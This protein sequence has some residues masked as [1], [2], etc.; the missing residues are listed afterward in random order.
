[1]TYFMG[2]W[3]CDHR[4]KSRTGVEWKQW[5]RKNRMYG[6]S[7]YTI[8]HL[9]GRGG[10]DEFDTILQSS[11]FWIPFAPFSSMQSEYF[12][13]M[14][15]NKSLSCMVLMRFHSKTQKMYNLTQLLFPSGLILGGGRGAIWLY[16][17]IAVLFDTQVLIDCDAYSHAQI[18]TLFLEHLE[19]KFK[20]L[21]FVVFMVTIMWNM[22][23][24]DR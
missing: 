17:S 18:F 1:M 13:T 11:F 12:P 22:K 7:D 2:I 15:P 9:R 24:Y 21:C 10:A 16:C 5:R 19:Y 4:N 8:L 23:F 20:V 14:P 6:N 3:Y